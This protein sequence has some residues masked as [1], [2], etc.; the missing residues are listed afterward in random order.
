MW[1]R[2]VNIALYLCM[3]ECV[4]YYTTCK[5]GWIPYKGSCYLFHFE[6]MSF[7]QAEA[8]DAIEN[9]FLKDRMRQ[10]EDHNWWMGLT[11]EDIEGVWQWF[12]TEEMPT[13]TD[14]RSGDGE[15][16]PRRTV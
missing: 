15:T 1:N 3:L 8:N 4:S 2:S 14:F 10:L 11:D 7:A 16:T 6:R 5:D 13:Y 12:D 9:E